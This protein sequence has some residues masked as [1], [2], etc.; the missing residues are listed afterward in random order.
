MFGVG[1]KHRVEHEVVEV[2]MFRGVVIVKVDE[3]LYVVVGADVPDG[4]E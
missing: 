2:G 3:V 1:G 4:L